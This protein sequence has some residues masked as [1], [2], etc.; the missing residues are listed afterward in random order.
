MS[1]SNR[2]IGPEPSAFDEETTETF[3][4]PLDRSHQQ[5]GG[6]PQPAGLYALIHA[7]LARTSQAR[8]M[9]RA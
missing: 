3:G 7:T 1:P 8:R 4:S 6:V 2:E 9:I 5:S